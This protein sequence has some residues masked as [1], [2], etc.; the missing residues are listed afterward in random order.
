VAGTTRAWLYIRDQESMR[1]EMRDGS[2]TLYGPGARLR[3]MEFADGAAATLAHLRLEQEL[4]GSGW[5]LEQ[6][7][8]ERRSGQERR[9]RP[10][11]TERRQLTVVRK[12]LP[13]S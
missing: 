5:S 8:T 3:T 4:V 6:M 2:L 7:T 9:A 12:R 13:F 10:R 11:G 1:V